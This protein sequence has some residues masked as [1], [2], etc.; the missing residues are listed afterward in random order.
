MPGHP[1]RCA[2][3]ISQPKISKGGVGLK[4][5]VKFIVVNGKQFEL[6]KGWDPSMAVETIHCE[7]PCSNLTKL[8]LPLT[9]IEAHYYEEPRCYSQCHMVGLKATW[10]KN[11]DKLAWA[12]VREDYSAPPIR[13]LS[14]NTT[15][16]NTIS[17]EQCPASSSFS[18]SSK[19]KNVKKRQ[20]GAKRLAKKPSRK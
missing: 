15:T 7:I 9:R 5:D 16:K 11:K 4:D 1:F 8:F 3:P 13:L 6:P 12:F 19:K 17:L 20:A 18:S 14:D 10:D 2:M